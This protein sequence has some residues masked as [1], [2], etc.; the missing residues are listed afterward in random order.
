MIERR[1]S[2]RHVCHLEAV[3]RPLESPDALCWGARVRNISV[4]GL[5]LLLCYPF[6]P[7]ASLAVDLHG[8]SRLGTQLVKVVHVREQGDGTWLVGCAFATPLD[9]AE[10]RAL[11]V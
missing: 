9:D 7:G 4:G 8:Q 1:A 5:S 2:V 3:S 11:L 6:K 10:L